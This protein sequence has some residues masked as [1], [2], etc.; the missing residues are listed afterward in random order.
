MINRFRALLHLVAYGFIDLGD[1][2]DE[3]QEWWQKM[4]HGERVRVKDIDVNVGDGYAVTERNGKKNESVWFK[5]EMRKYVNR[6]VTLK[7]HG[8][9]WSFNEIE[10]QDEHFLWFAEFFEPSEVDN[11]CVDAKK[12]INNSLVDTGGWGLGKALV[13]MLEGRKMAYCSES[14]KISYKCFHD[15]TIQPALCEHIAEEHHHLMQ[16]IVRNYRCFMKSEVDMDFILSVPVSFL[17]KKDFKELWKSNN[18]SFFCEQ[19]RHIWRKLKSENEEY[20]CKGGTPF[21]TF[22]SDIEYGRYEKKYNGHGIKS[23][24][25]YIHDDYSGNVL[26]KSEKADFYFGLAYTTLESLEYY[27]N[28]R[29]RI[30]HNNSGLHSFMFSIMTLLS[31]PDKL[32][33]NVIDHASIKG[34][35]AIPLLFIRSFKKIPPNILLEALFKL[36]PI[37]ELR[38]RPEIVVKNGYRPETDKMLRDLKKL[39]STL[40]QRSN[41]LCG[42]N[43][44][45]ALSK[46]VDVIINDI[47]KIRYWINCRNDTDPVNN[48]FF[49]EDVKYVGDKFS[50]GDQVLIY[51]MGKGNKMICS[52]VEVISPVQPNPSPFKWTTPRGKTVIFDYIVPVKLIIPYQGKSVSLSELRNILGYGNKWNPVGKGGTFSIKNKD[53]FDKIHE[54]LL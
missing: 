28:S 40:K 31:L 44:I 18:D 51:T 46:E 11:L 20:P 24:G 25:I 16:N 38:E 48:L 17:P 43:N 10:D 7:E 6:S 52:M 33:H 5:P 54:K 2:V 8:N 36:L 32:V 47:K 13:E 34:P 41:K 26:K 37:E 22:L 3:Q 19:F 42:L 12:P 45:T 15:S 23:P 27:F 50:K 4:K 1:V 35:W 9:A 30:I 53:D 29:S 39:W 21:I 14:E 49:Y